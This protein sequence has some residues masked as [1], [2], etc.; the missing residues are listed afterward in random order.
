M[1]HVPIT[2]LSPVIYGPDIAVFSYDLVV[3]EPI[4]EERALPHNN[5]SR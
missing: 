1:Y 3:G 2:F 5:L 4:L